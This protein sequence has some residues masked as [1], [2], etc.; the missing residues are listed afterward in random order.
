MANF[1]FYD[2]ESRQPFN[3]LTSRKFNKSKFSS[4]CGLLVRKKNFNKFIKLPMNPKKRTAHFLLIFISCLTRLTPKKKV[5][6]APT[7]LSL[8][9]SP[10]KTLFAVYKKKL[11]VFW[12]ANYY[13]TGGCKNNDN[14]RS[15]FK[16]HHN[17]QIVCLYFY[18][19]IEIMHNSLPRRQNNN[20]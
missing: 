1:S 20:E 8:S 10:K 19:K 14:W 15:S 2:D 18:S 7:P 6:Q 4:A 17:H 3:F 9:S 12:D 16:S 5:I 13:H 11:K